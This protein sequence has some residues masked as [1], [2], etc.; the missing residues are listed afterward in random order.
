[1]HSLNFFFFK[2]QNITGTHA[3]L[4]TKIFLSLLQHKHDAGFCV[5]NFLILLYNCMTCVCFLK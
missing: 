2:Q 1:M 4:M 5:N 3:I